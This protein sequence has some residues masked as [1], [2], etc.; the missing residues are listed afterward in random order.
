MSLTLRDYI[1]SG[2][3]F[4]NC[5]FPKNVLVNGPLAKVELPPSTTKWKHCLV[6]KQ[7]VLQVCFRMAAHAQISFCNVLWMPWRF[8]L[9]ELGALPLYEIKKGFI[10][11]A[12]CFFFK[13]VVRLTSLGAEIE[14]P[15]WIPFRISAMT[16]SQR[17]ASRFNAWWKSP[18]KTP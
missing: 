18:L 3:L 8:A 5:A 6:V 10:H 11:S 9:A 1:A 2:L 7:T 15:S 14:A 13:W 17:F 4:V 16:K 12:S